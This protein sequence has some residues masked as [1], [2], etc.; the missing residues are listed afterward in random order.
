VVESLTSNEA[1][2]RAVNNA[3]FFVPEICSKSESTGV[4]GEYRYMPWLERPTDAEKAKSAALR[5]RLVKAAKCPTR[6]FRDDLRASTRKQTDD[7]NKTWFTHESEAI[8]VPVEYQRTEET[9]T[10]LIKG[11]KYN[12]AD[13]AKTG[14]LVPVTGRSNIQ[15]AGRFTVVTQREWSGE[16]KIRTEVE[17]PAASPPLQSGER[18]T[19]EL[20]MRGAVAI[21]DSCHYMAKKH[22]GFSTFLTLTFD[23]DARGRMAA[24][25]STIQKEASRFF[26]G[27]QKMY[28][29]GWQAKTDFQ[30]IK[31]PANDHKLKYCWVA[32]NPLNA[33]GEDNPHLHVLMDWRVPFA[34]FEAWTKR[35]EG[36]WG[37][38]FAHLEK[39]KD[40]EQAGAYMAKAAGYMTKAQ[41]ASD[42]GEIRGNRYGISA[43]ARA[44]EWSLVGR[45]E[46]GIMGH[47]IADVY[48]FFGFKYGPKYKA[49]KKLN[50]ALNVAKATAKDLKDT[51]QRQTP[52]QLAR[53]AK[54][55]HKLQKVR[56]AINELPAVSS[57][58]QILIKSKT[59]F[60]E[61][62]AWA[63]NAEKGE[64]CE[65]LP[66]ISKDETWDPDNVPS[67][68]WYGEYMHRIGDRRR[69]FFYEVGAKWWKK[70]D[71]LSGH[72]RDEEQ[73]T[74]ENEY[75]EY[76]TL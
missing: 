75:S 54:I 68:L 55:G 6:Q 65:W 74:F 62:W 14:E 50:E 34:V 20:S 56:A 70:I 63:T 11:Q 43:D 27:I 2:E 30:S 51:K 38:G 17:Q 69:N 53:R 49:R 46:L 7:F 28:Q 15:G 58:Y 48:D 67:S 24:G 37:Q 72:F 3:R 33:T 61:F 8:P 31:M 21:S 40:P 73:D 25:E 23:D 1:I 41:G 76:L 71:L 39:I 36:I 52:E 13:M 18:I 4:M 60:D 29:R 42:Q 44:P 66:T 57:K 45:Y 64:Q 47:L 59:A 9:N 5:Y 19:K 22:G 12:L 16:F 10:V 35:I 26:D 32:E